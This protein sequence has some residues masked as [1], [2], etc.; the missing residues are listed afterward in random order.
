LISQ[1]VQCNTD[2]SAAHRDI[3]AIGG[4]GCDGAELLGEAEGAS[5]LA[6]AQAM[7]IESPDRCQPVPPDPRDLGKLASFRQGGVY[8]RAAAR[9]GVPESVGQREIQ[10]HVA[11]WIGSHLTSEACDGLIDSGPTFIQ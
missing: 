5:I 2:E 8:L 4:L 11:A 7:E 10:A 9:P 1:D 6:P 3:G